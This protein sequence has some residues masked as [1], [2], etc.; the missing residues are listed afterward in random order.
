MGASA[1]YTLPPALLQQ[2]AYSFLPP[3]TEL[4]LFLS[5][6]RLSC[7]FSAPHGLSYTFLHI[8]PCSVLGRRPQAMHSH[9]HGERSSPMILASLGR[10]DN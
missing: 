3:V 6:S 5:I 7:M 4:F 10:K 8:V 1:D 2:L 9:F